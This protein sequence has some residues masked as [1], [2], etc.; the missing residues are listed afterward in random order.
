MSVLPEGKGKKHGPA[1]AISLME[2]ASAPNARKRAARNTCLSKYVSLDMDPS[3]SAA[4]L[5]LHASGNS[6]LLRA[7]LRMLV[8][9]DSVC[10]FVLINIIRHFAG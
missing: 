9:K 3:N 8:V 5:C 2:F 7:L 6:Q 10:E 4:C 1:T